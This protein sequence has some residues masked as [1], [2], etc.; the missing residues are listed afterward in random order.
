MVVTPAGFRAMYVCLCK[1]V[2]DRQIR[3]AVAQGATRMRDLRV[4]LGV[5][6]CCGR[7]AGCAREILREARAAASPPRAG[8]AC[9][10]DPALAEAS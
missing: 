7:C 10:L 9:R 5:A 4:A 8:A 6:S 1:A 3:E 2:T